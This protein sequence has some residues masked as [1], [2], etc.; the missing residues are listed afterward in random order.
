MDAKLEYYFRT[1]AYDIVITHVKIVMDL[2]NKLQKQ[3]REGGDVIPLFNAVTVAEKRLKE[4]TDHW[5]YLS[6]RPQTWETYDIVFEHLSKQLSE[7]L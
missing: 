7:S 3:Y 6:C 4:A 1:S 2:H 5:A